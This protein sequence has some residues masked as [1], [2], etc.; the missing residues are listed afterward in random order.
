MEDRHILE[1]LSCFEF[2]EKQVECA[3]DIANNYIK[4]A[5]KFLTGDSPKWSILEHLRALP[6]T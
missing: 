2:D 5:Y 1:T 4:K 6:F 3:L